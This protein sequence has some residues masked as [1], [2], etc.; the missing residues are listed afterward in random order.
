[1]LN[2][3]YTNTGINVQYIKGIDI[4]WKVKG[5]IKENYQWQPKGQTESRQAKAG[6]PIIY[7]GLGLVS[8]C[9][10]SVHFNF[11]FLARVGTNTD[12]SWVTDTS[13]ESI[14]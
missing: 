4:R 14:F 12:F 8:I 13:S 6:K 7:V 2:I 3:T 5:N 1:M 10:E 11:I 9:S